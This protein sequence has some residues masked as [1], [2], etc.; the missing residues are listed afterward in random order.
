MTRRFPCWIDAYVDYVQDDPAPELYKLWTAIYTVGVA[1][2]RRV[3]VHTRSILFPNLYILLVG[4]PGVGKS[5]AIN[6]AL[7]ILRKSGTYKVFPQDLTGSATLDYLASEN[8]RKRLVT[9]Q[10]IAIQYHPGAMLIS[11][12]GTMIREYDLPFLS[13]LSTLYDC[14]EHYEQHRRYRAKEPVIIPHPS[15]AFLAGTQPDY[16]STVLPNEAWGQGFMSRVVMIY[17]NQKLKADLFSSKRLDPLAAD[18]LTA[19][20]VSM[21]SMYGEY[22]FAEEVIDAFRAWYGED[23]PPIPQPHRLVGYNQRRAITFQKLL[24]IS[25]ASRQSALHIEIEDFHR[26]QGWLLQAEACM[27]NIFLEM[28]GRSDID[29]IRDFHAWALREYMGKKQKPLHASLIET[30]LQSKVPVWQ[31][32]KIFKSLETSGLIERMAGT[33]TYIPKPKYY[34]PIEEME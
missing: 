33:E 29:T 10:Q 32:E 16:L 23:M 24:M 1:L 2:E 30:Y 21:E 27:P 28:A 20:L 34:N 15:M 4:N 8:V 22:I 7:S 25:A 26:A 9:D 31:A 19:D 14:P 11:E 6:P 5:V 12:F 18:A 17:S 3:W 13:I